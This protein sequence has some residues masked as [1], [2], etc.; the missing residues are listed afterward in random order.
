MKLKKFEKLRLKLNKWKLKNWIEIELKLNWNWI[1]NWKIELKLNW[2]IEKLKNW[3]EMN[4]KIEKLKN[5]NEKLNWN[6]IEIE[7][8]KIELKLNWKLKIEKF[9]NKSDE[10]FEWIELIWKIVFRH[11]NKNKNE[12]CLASGK[13]GDQCDFNTDCLD[14]MFCSQGQ[15]VCLSNY[16]QRG[17]YCYESNQII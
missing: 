5:W 3:I 2:K 10:M 6:W 11:E 9:W 1:V 12:F 13:V 4:W 7:N 15:C 8:W 17:D 14:G 16:V